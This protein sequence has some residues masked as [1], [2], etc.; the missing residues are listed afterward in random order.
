MQNKVT[1]SLLL[2]LFN[3]RG[4]F[5]EDGQF[6]GENGDDATTGGNERINNEL[7]EIKTECLLSNRK[8]K[9]GISQ[10]DEQVGSLPTQIIF[11]A[12]E[13]REEELEVQWTAE[14]G[15]SHGDIG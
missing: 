9:R 10:K 6:G 15:K 3:W 5:L 1:I 7:E 13:R 8:T 11:I 4:S 2:F 12:K 14:V